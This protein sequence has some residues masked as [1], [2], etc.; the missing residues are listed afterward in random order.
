MGKATLFIAAGHGGRDAGNVATGHVER[1]ELVAF[2]GGMRR[3]FAATRTAPGLGGVVMLDDHL[4]LRGEVAEIGRWRPMARD[5]DLAV[6][7]HLDYRA[8]ERGGALVVYD[9]SAYGRQWAE[10]W[11]ER[12]CA[13]TGIRS[14][15]VH[16][17]TEAARRWRGWS[18]YGFTAPAWP[19]AIVELGCINHAADLAI[20]RDPF[21]QAFAA[22]LLV[23]TW[24]EIG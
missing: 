12:W 10:T 6:D 21:W 5:G 7:V 24:K 22:H 17:S 4:D 9:E 11:L 14:A 8:N 20:V 23:A 16:R 1:D 19:G 15:G 18:D 13:A 3:W 2:V